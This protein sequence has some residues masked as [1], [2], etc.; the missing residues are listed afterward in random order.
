[1]L[2]GE[3][4][5]LNHFLSASESEFFRVLSAGHSSPTATAQD[6]PSSAGNWVQVPVLYPCAGHKM[7]KY[8]LAPAARVLLAKAVSYYWDRFDSLQSCE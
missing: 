6:K 7:D 3:Q 4:G 1:M 2:G 5:E 8:T